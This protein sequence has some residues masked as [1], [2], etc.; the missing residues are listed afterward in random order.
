[1]ALDAANNLFIADY[2]YGVIRKISSGII[3]RIA[4]TCISGYSG[5]GGS[6]IL[7]QI[8][9]AERFAFDASG[10]I[11][12]SDENNQRVRVVCFASCSLGFD[13]IKNSTSLKIFPNQA[14]NIL[15]IETEQ[16]NLDNSE[17]EITNS[18]GQ[19]ILKL[20]YSKTIDVSKLQEGFYYLKINSLGK[21]T[22]SS[23]FIKQ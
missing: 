12:I 3:S 20:P 5:D 1:M 16:T 18:L 22:Y 23:K 2:N 6:A 13:E 8:K 4:G 21:P 11:Y 7:A 9:P 10:N 15:Q 17:I 14:S 19:T